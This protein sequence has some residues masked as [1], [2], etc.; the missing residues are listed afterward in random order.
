MLEEDDPEFYPAISQKR[1][2]ELGQLVWS[3]TTFKVGRVTMQATP[4]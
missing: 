2:L 3:A 1:E 4:E